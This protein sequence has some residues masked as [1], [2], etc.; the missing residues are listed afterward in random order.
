MSSAQGRFTS[1]GPANASAHA[2]NPQSWNAYSYANN[3]PLNL[4]DRNGFEPVKA[5]AGTIQG[6]AQNMNSTPHRVGLATGDSAA[7]ALSSLGETKNLLPVNTGIFNMSANRYVYTANGGWIDMVHFV[8]YAGRA[9]K[10]KL[11]GNANPVGEAVQDGYW[12]EWSDQI[13]DPWSAYSYEDLPSDLFGAEF[14]AQ[15]FDPTSSLTL[16]EQLETFIAYLKPLAPTSAPNYARLPQNDS[17]NPPIARN[18]STNPMFTSWWSRSMLDQ[19]LTP[20]VT[21]SIHY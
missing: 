13:R 10:Y 11:A 8:F 19:D 2:I 4:V 16:A 6:F 1:P 5:Q 9:F 3:R 15:L 21:S 17:K 18:K 12:Q 14:G 7:S 20:V